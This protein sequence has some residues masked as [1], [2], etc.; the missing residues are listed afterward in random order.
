MIK[1]ARNCFSNSYSHTKSGSLW[2]DGKDISWM[3]IVRLYEE[4][5]E[6]NLYTPCPKL[7]RGQD[8]TAF[9]RMKVSFAAQ[10]FSTT[11]ANSLEML[12][13]ESVEETVKFVRTMNKFFDCLNVRN[14]YEGRNKRN[15]D[16]N[17][18]TNPEDERRR[19]Q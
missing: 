12:Y 17:A 13:D 10:V 3:H 15:P 8:L 18:Y 1:T 9:S 7:T 11:I 4:H 14:P 5:C 19:V 16:L 6:Q 2:K